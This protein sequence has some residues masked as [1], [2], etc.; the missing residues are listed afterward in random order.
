MSLGVQGCKCNGAL[1]LVRNA[2]TG[3]GHCQPGN[4]VSLALALPVAICGALVVALLVLLVWTW[5]VLNKEQLLKSH[6]PPGQPLVIVRARSSDTPQLQGISGV[7]RPVEGLQ[8]CC[9]AMLGSWPA[10]C[11]CCDVRQAAARPEAG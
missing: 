7:V 8:G 10:C 6:G 4:K 11:L 2:S 5:F 3:R 9:D 1:E